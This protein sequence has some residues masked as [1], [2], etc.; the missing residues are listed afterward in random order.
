[1]ADPRYAGALRLDG[2]RALITGAT[3]GIG[4]DIARAFASAGA[5]LVLSGR[6]TEELRAA[7]SALSTEPKSTPSQSI[8]RGPK[9][10]P[11]WPSV[12]R[13]HSVG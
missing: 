9:E 6:D 4:A 11:N 3:K 1:M 7:R 13:T 12:P 2:K 10:P 5:T 8:S